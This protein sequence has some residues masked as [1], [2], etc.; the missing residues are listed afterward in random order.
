MK[1]RPVLTILIIIF[2]CSDLYA[3]IRVYMLPQAEI[4]GREIFVGDICKIE[5]PGAGR[6]L[7]FTIPPVLYSDSIIDKEELKNIL[8]SVSGE[9]IS[10]FGNGTMIIFSEGTVV[11]DTSQQL[12]SIRKGETVRVEM[13]NGN[14]I[15]VLQGKSLDN[16]SID[17]QIDV[18]LKNGKK[19]R[20][21]VTGEKQVRMII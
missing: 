14:I 12:L 17:D 5:G 13:K 1:I 3:A 20:C 16:G 15:I 2:V 6:F 19:V 7:G 4:T 10:V 21:I 18:K 8:S 11:K 9:N